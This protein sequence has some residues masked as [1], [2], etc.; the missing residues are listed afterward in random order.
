MI[1]SACQEQSL[2]VCHIV[3]NTPYSR[4]A[5]EIAAYPEVG[6]EKHIL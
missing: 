4:Q 1:I 6:Q 5:H 2:T 3:H